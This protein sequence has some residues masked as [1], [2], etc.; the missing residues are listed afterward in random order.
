MENK[1]NVSKKLRFDVFK[2]D[3]FTCQY[4]GSTPPSVVL[5]CDHIDP[6]SKGG[7]N[8]LYN[9]ITACF[10]C[11]RGKS[12]K[13]LS[14][15]PESIKEKHSVLIEKDL[16]FVEYQKL[17]KKHN[18]RINKEIKDVSDIFESEFEGFSLKDRFKNS[19]IKM[20]IEKLN[21]HDV[22]EAMYISCSRQVEPEYAIK[23]FCGICWRKIKEN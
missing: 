11:N 9:L 5:E 1:R 16:Q 8:D 10:D 21:V 13:T 7:T 6:I 23:Y 12:D 18:R 22:K 3:S 2:R 19:S 20:F 14:N 4:C 15:I 17:L